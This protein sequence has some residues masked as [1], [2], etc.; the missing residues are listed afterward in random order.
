M[1]FF[2]NYFHIRDLGKHFPLNI[3]TSEASDECFFLIKLTSEASDEYFFLI[4]LTSEAS[5]ECFSFLQLSAPGTTD[6]S[7]QGKKAA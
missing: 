3:F 4:K 2:V 7:A 6:V 1:I 5:D